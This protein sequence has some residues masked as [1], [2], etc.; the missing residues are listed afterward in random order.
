MVKTDWT[1]IIQ[2]SKKNTS[3]PVHVLHVFILVQDRLHWLVTSCWWS[4][5][6]SSIKAFWPETQLVQCQKEQNGEGA[7]TASLCFVRNSELEMKAAT[8]NFT[9]IDCLIP[10]SPACGDRPKCSRLR[11]P[12]YCKMLSVLLLPSKDTLAKMKKCM[13]Q[14][15]SPT[16]NVT[17]YRMLPVRNWM[18]YNCCISIPSGYLT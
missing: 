1:R 12:L 8:G 14:L 2:G 3:K 16:W 10:A 9:I 5:G 4:Q 6:S 7:Q 15:R 17:R 11:T 13:A 18:L